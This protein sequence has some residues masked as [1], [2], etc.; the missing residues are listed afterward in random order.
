MR[1]ATPDPLSI[2]EPKFFVSI[3]FPIGRE[4]ATIWE[5]CGANPGPTHTHRFGL[6]LQPT[7]IWTSS[8]MGRGR[9][10]VKLEGNR[11]A[12]VLSV[13]LLLV[14]S[15]LMIGLAP[16]ARADG[17][18]YTVT[19]DPSNSTGDSFSISFDTTSIL[20]SSLVTIDP[21]DVKVLNA[22]FQ[23]LPA[24]GFYVLGDITV[25]DD[26]FAVTLQRERC[27]GGCNN[28]SN[29]LD[30]QIT[31]NAHL[32]NPITSPGTYQTPDIT[33]G[34]QMQYYVVG[35]GPPF[36]YVDPGATV[37]LMATPEPNSGL[38]FGGCFLLCA[39]VALRRKIRML[40]Q[41]IPKTS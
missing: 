16:S 13:R 2:P 9:G 3:E 39:A 22:E 28:I 32:L 30:D 25:R 18:Q 21:G 40:W 38:M 19:F 27:P 17:Y 36:T 11:R 14:C 20:G 7:S 33:G 26:Y 4:S 12:A 10:M 35:G 6:P 31:G 5:A 37:T 24:S 8:L 29:Y 41:T 23:G 34:S 1:S 15:F